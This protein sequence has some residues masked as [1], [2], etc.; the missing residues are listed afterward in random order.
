MRYDGYTQNRPWFG[1]VLHPLKEPNIAH[2]GTDPKHVEYEVNV[3]V[4][5]VVRE[6]TG[7]ELDPGLLEDPKCSTGKPD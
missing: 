6:L 3:V 1:E 5:D 4:V 7:S 2:L